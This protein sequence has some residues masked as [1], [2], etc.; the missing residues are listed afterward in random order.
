MER[1]QSTARELIAFSLPL[2]LSGIL[3]QLY[4]WADA[5]IVGHAEGAAWTL[6]LLIFIARMM[7][8]RRK[9]A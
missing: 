4:S 8:V 5:F 3:Q 2:I 1:K 9:A 6:T 7:R